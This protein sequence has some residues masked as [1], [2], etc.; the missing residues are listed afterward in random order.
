MTSQ[1]T[2]F[3]I[4]LVEISGK[5]ELEGRTEELPQGLKRISEV[6]IPVPQGLPK[7]CYA[8]EL[9]DIV[10]DSVAPRKSLGR[11]GPGVDG[12]ALNDIYALGLAGREP[13]PGGT[14]SARRRR[15]RNGGP[16]PC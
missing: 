5:V 13:G 6:E 16:V 7:S 3:R 1:P 4:P 9:T 2:P 8:L 10:K 12:V 15:S 14:S 11:V